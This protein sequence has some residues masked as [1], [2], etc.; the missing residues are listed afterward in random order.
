MSAPVFARLYE[1]GF[2]FIE[3]GQCQLERILSLGLMGRLDMKINR[4]E[5]YELYGKYI[6][7][8]RERERERNRYFVRPAIWFCTWLF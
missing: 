1:P 3:S 2:S 5:V 7:I 6:Y 4:S 8:E